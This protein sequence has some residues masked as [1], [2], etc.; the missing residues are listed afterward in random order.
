MMSKP[1]Q[2]E[3]EELV[4]YKDDDETYHM[5]FDKLLEDKLKELDP[6]WI[7]AMLKLYQETNLARWYA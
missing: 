7:E 3:I 2:R 1:T 6:E 5:V 4:K